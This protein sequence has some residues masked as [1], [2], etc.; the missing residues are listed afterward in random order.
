MSDSK[1]RG[2]RRTDNIKGGSF[3]IKTSHVI[4]ICVALMTL[5][6]AM[7]KSKSDAIETN[8][9]KPSRIEINTKIKE[10]TSGF[11]GQKEYEAH[12]IKNDLEYKVTNDKIDLIQ[13]FQAKEFKNIDNKIELVLEAVKN[14]K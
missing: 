6:F 9:A 7:L 11:V 8:T 14:K 4:T 3:Y 13:K 5:F 10:A 2:N 12:E 1:N